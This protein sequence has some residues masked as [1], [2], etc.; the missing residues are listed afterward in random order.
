MNRSSKLISLILTLALAL[1]LVPAARAVDEASTSTFTAA[2]IYVT[3]AD[4]DGQI[5]FGLASDIKSVRIDN[6]SAHSVTTLAAAL[7]ES[8]EAAFRSSGTSNVELDYVSY[9]MVSP[10]QG[11]LYDGY[12][13]EGDPGIGVAA[14]QR[15]YYSDTTASNYKI[16]DLRFVP[17]P[18]F[19]GMATITYYGHCTYTTTD[20]E[21]NLISAQG[22]C[23]GKIYISVSK[24]VPGISYATDGEAVLFSAEDFSTYSLAVTGRNFRYITFTPPKASEGALYYNYRDESIYDY[25]VT[26]SQR[27]YRANKPLLSNVCFVPAKNAPSTVD[28]RFH[29]VDIADKSPENTNHITITVTTHGPQYAGTGDTGTINYEVEQGRSVTLKASDFSTLCRNETGSS[30]DYIRFPALPSYGTL[31]DSSYSYSSSNN[32]N[33]YVSANRTYSSPGNIRYAADSDYVGAESVPVV[34]Y[35]DNGQWFDATVCFVVRTGKTSPLQ[36]RVDPGK[37]VYFVAEDFSDACYAATGYNINRIRFHSLPSSYYGALYN[38]GTPIT[39]NGS[40]TYYYRNSLN[41]LS[42]LASGDFTDSISIPFTGYATNY[43]SSNGRSFSGSITITSTKAAANTSTAAIGGTARTITYRTAQYPAYLRGSDIVSAAAPSLPG[44]VTEVTLT[45]PDTAAGTL[46]R[47]FVTLAS[48]S[49]F[50]PRQSYQ[51]SDISRVAFL[52]K[53]GFSGTT[54]ISYTAKDAKGNSYTGNIDFVVTP[55]TYSSFFSDLGNHVWAVPAVDFFR[56]YGVTNGISPRYFGPDL[57]M[58]R[59][60]FV[61]LLS[62]ACGFPDAGTESFA[63]VPEDTWYSA[64]IASAKSLNIVS[65]ST[66]GTFYPDGTISREEAATYLYRALRLYRG[67]EAG[68][69]ADIAR[70]SDAD[71]VSSVAVSAMGALVRL[72]IID[73]I[74]GR[75]L[76]HK[77]LTRAEAMTILYRAFT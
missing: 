47:D 57:P 40:N 18:S 44:E 53:A 8:C 46:A 38:S 63:D 64:A 39:T 13:T 68:T 77:T 76:P 61:L 31:Y 33:Y 30:L 50:D 3:P 14:A 75:L 70:Y 20:A 27:F 74:S 23:G 11:T 66:S 60:D 56:A 24:Q 26:A 48:Y 28:I 10:R 6:P 5:S 29:L 2:D 4:E 15:Y 21:E 34:I 25:E 9:L 58:R 73:G 12:S 41:N 55:P 69:A 32:S 59:G 19:S 52:P 45:R 72:G 1:T 36:Y 17:S 51:P 43:T 49:A 67:A 42:F 37:R 62:R 54:Q 35:A 71:S 22:S 65:G 16:S 7:K